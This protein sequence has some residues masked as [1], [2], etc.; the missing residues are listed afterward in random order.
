VYSAWKKLYS[1][2]L[3]KESSITIGEY[4]F[5]SLINTAKWSYVEDCV[6]AAD[7]N[8]GSLVTKNREMFLQPNVVVKWSEFLIHIWEILGDQL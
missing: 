1:A 4:L 6:W 7:S 8:C 5:F 2:Y 3:T